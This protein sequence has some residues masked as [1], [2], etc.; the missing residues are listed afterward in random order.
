MEISKIW[1]GRSP[2]TMQWDVWT[3]SFRS[4][5]GRHVE[6]AP[7]GH[8]GGHM[9]TFSYAMVLEHVTLSLL[10]LGYTRI[11]LYTYRLKCH[12]GSYGV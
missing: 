3:A 12:R 2:L 10:K 4:Q 5:R 9:A 6:V 1:R 7:F 8:S 11:V